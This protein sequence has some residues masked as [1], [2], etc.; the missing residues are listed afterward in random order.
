[1]LCTLR[2]ADIDTCTAS[3]TSSTGTT[4]FCS[5]PRRCVLID[6]DL[7]IFVHR[8]NHSAGYRI[9][10]FDLTVG[11]LEGSTHSHSPRHD[12]ES[13]F[14]VLLWLCTHY[15]R[16]RSGAMERRRDQYPEMTFARSTG[17]ADIVQKGLSP[18][19]PMGTGIQFVRKVMPTL[20]PAAK[21]KLATVFRKWRSCCFHQRW[22]RL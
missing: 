13:C 4:S 6:F 11:I 1:V 18:R 21:E 5:R 20:D 8:T 14:Y 10:T 2:F 15:T 19:A 12:L 22:K 9:G 16:G 7:A 17:C 3:T